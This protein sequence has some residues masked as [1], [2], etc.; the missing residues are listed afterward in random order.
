MEEG[1]SGTGLKK[2]LKR[3]DGKDGNGGEGA[4]GLDT[5]RTGGDGGSRGGGDAS[6]VWSRSDSGYV[7]LI[8]IKKTSYVFHLISVFQVPG[9]RGGRPQIH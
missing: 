9:R 1:D 4:G 2:V 3:G 6:A 5:M 7:N 8:G